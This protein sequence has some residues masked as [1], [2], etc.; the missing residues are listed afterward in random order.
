MAATRKLFIRYHCGHGGWPALSAAIRRRLKA[1]PHYSEGQTDFAWA[2]DV[3][4]VGA[5]ELVVLNT[6]RQPHVSIV[7]PTYGEHEVT[8]RCLASLAAHPLDV[9]YEVIVI[10]DAY[11]EPLDLASMG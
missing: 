4:V 9:P 5:D 8:R 11:A 7:I 3:D 2:S 6:S 10:D 1:R